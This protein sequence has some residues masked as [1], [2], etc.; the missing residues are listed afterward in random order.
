MA[1][2][3]SS[4]LEEK[5]EDAA[6]E[7]PA[8]WVMALPSSMFLVEDAAQRGEAESAGKKKQQSAGISWTEDGTPFLYLL[9]GK[10]WKMLRTNA[11]LDG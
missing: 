5:M 11:Q 9:T 2:P 10:K 6:D 8:G 7:R 1:L 4:Y 3:S